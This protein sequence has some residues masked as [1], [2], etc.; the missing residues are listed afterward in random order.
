MHIIFFWNSWVGGTS[1][2]ASGLKIGTRPR[3]SFDFPTNDRLGDS[4]YD[5]FS[6]QT[7]SKSIKSFKRRLNNDFL[8]KLCYKVLIWNIFKAK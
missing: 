7:M 6:K 3:S 2:D 5:L 1:E 4:A 8:R